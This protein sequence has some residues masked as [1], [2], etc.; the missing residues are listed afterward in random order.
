MARLL[1]GVG[2]APDDRL[3]H[4]VV[5]DHVAA[6]GGLAHHGLV[7]L[8][9]DVVLD[10]AV[11]PRVEDAVGIGALVVVAGVV[12]V[13]AAHLGPVDGVLEV[14]VPSGP[15]VL[16]AV[17]LD[18]LDPRIRG[19]VHHDHVLRV[20]GSGGAPHGEVLEA[21][22]ADHVGGAA[23][24]SPHLGVLDRGEGDVKRAPST[25]D[26]VVDGEGVPA[27]GED[28][29]PLRD[30][31]VPVGRVRELALQ[32]RPP[33][34]SRRRAISSTTSCPA[35]R[36]TRPARSPCRRPAGRSGGCRRRQSGWRRRR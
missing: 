23:G 15:R 31:P 29:D 34:G 9:Y 32:I 26:R 25:G 6:A 17:R 14:D 33:R 27:L 28:F 22:V 21:G 30:G 3:V 2:E 36:P 8:P 24:R 19:A 10:Q 4:V 1:P 12:R 11:A 18:V 20:S 7:E 13:A 5:G 35:S 16:R